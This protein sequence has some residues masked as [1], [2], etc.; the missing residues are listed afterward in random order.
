MGFQPVDQALDQGETH[1]AAAPFIERFL[2]G[3]VTAQGRFAG[4]GHLQEGEFVGAGPH[5]VDAGEHIDHA[6]LD[7]LLPILGGF[8][9]PATEDV[10]GIVGD[11]VAVDPV[12][13]EEGDPERG[14]IAFLPRH[15]GYGNGAVAANQAHNADLAVEVLIR[16]EREGIGRGRQAADEAAGALAAVFL[17]AQVE[18]QG[19]KLRQVDPL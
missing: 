15:R 13:D 5:A 10:R 14:A 2:P 8:G 4:V 3:N 9:Q 17:P 12:H 11:H 19:F 1:A 6:P 18:Q 7:V 16:E